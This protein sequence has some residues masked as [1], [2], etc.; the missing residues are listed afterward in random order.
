MDVLTGTFNDTCNIEDIVVTGLDANSF[1]W[2][3]LEL[4]KLTHDTTH[5]S[6]WK[7]L[8]ERIHSGKKEQF[9]NKMCRP[10]LVFRES[11]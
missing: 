10:W 5:D 2:V 3:L 9:V 6:G 1:G 4:T 8:R 7:G 11:L